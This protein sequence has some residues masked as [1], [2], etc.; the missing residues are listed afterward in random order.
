MRIFSKIE[1]GNQEILAA[2][3]FKPK[4]LG[5]AGAMFENGCLIK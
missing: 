1:V 4:E 2:D 3:I 5:M